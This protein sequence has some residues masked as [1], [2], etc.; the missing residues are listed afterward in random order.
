MSSVVDAHPLHV[1]VPGCGLNPPWLGADRDLQ[2]RLRAS[3]PARSTFTTTPG[4][5]FEHAASAAAAKARPQAMRSTARHGQCAVGPGDDQLV[6]R[7]RLGVGDRAR[8]DRGRADQRPEPPLLIPARRLAAR[9]DRH[10]DL[11]PEGQGRR[12]ALG[13][14]A[15][16]LVQRAHVVVDARAR[17]ERRRRDGQRRGRRRRARSERARVR[18]AVAELQRRHH[19]LAVA[20]DL[21]VDARRLVRGRLAGRRLHQAQAAARRRLARRLQRG[22]LLALRL[23]DLDRRPQLQRPPEL[24]PRRPADRPCPAA[25]RPRSR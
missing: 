19:L 11:Q 8:A 20:L 17:R 13:H 5:S 24:A 2:V 16:V 15:A 23:G 4:S 25:T 3:N 10:R 18:R 22:G 9:L 12:A 14:H 21:H 6:R 7:P 1:V